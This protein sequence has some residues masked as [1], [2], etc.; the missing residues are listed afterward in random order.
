MKFYNYVKH[1]WGGDANLTEEY[2]YNNSDNLEEL[3]PVYSGKKYSSIGNVNK[4]ACKRII[5]NSSYTI[6][7]SRKGDAGFAELIE[8]D[9]FAIT[10]DAYIIQLDDTKVDADITK[11]IIGF[12]YMKKALFCSSLNSNGTL[13]KGKLLETEI[14]INDMKF[15]NMYDYMQKKKFNSKI[16]ELSK[17]LIS[18]NLVCSGNEVQFHEMF[19]IYKGDSKLTEEYIYNNSDDVNNLIK[20]Y[21]GAIAFNDVYINEN[22][23]A[24]VYSGKYLRVLKDGVNAGYIEIVSG[25]FTINSHTYLLIP[26]GEYQIYFDYFT[27]ILKPYI[28]RV[29][30]DKTGNPTT[31]FGKLKEQYVKLPTTEEFNMLECVNKLNDVNKKLI[32][33]S[34]F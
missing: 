21:T 5:N 17:K 7:V 8:V 9:E 14:D 10:D 15:K 11:F 12:I 31:N 28:K 24:K 2:I 23:C 19:E 25:K 6:K 30:N 18:T 20:V 26:K 29:L 22:A 27:E 3:I 32:N 33:I 4:S 16:Q 13:N 1:F 34:Q